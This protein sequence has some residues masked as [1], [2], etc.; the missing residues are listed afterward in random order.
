MAISVVPA[1]KDRDMESPQP[2]ILVQGLKKVFRQNAGRSSPWRILLSR[3][4][5]EPVVALNNLDLE[6]RRGEFFSLLGPNGAGKTS[7]I[8]TLC[9]LLLPDGGRCQ[10]AGFDVVKSPLAVRRSIG[11]SIRGER[12]VYWKLTGRQNLEYFSKLY[13]IRG[14]EAAAR[15]EEVAEVVGLKDR[16][17]DFVERY[18]MGM[19]QRLALG[20]SL[21][22]R[23][24][25]LL[26]DEPTIG[27]DP[28]GARAL[29]TLLKEE[30]C[31]RQGVTVL[32]TTHYMN[33]AETL[34]DR[35]AIIHRGE[36]VTDG[37]PSQVRASLGDARVIELV[38]RGD[39]SKIQRALSVLRLV[40]RVVVMSDDGNVSV[41]R[42]HTNEPMNSV[43]EFPS[44]AV[45]AA[46]V[47]SIQLVTPSL[48][49]AFISLTGSSISSEGQV[50]PVA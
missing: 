35:L 34:S 28:H 21:I 4:R 23:P 22:H 46:Q 44:D 1:V 8:K 15:V 31:G 9:T 13:G 33:E 32:Y 24:Q 2:M 26:L 11:V 39:G 38:A 14:A 45:P 25:V 36:V 18:S 42:I 17:D 40:E 20:A 7:L 6:V 41:I 48:E 16:L 49:D 5:T 47:L 50:E 19:K 12:S 37:T 27:L 43:S 3:Q 30:L 29:R 10:V